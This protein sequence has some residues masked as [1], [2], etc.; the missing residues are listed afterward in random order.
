MA[1][2]SVGI[3]VVLILIFGFSIISGCFSIPQLG[4][5]VENIDNRSR[6]I[7]FYGLVENETTGRNNTT[8]EATSPEE[9]LTFWDYIEG[10]L[11]F[12]IGTYTF[13]KIVR[14]IL[15]NIELEDQPPLVP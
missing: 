6:I 5:T 1:T 7:P 10:I 14:W 2:T 12:I 8:V 15:K 4:I 3:S 9:E 13:I 11:I